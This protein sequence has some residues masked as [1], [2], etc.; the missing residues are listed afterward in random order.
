MSQNSKHSAALEDV[1]TERQRQ[2]ESD[3][4]T[5]EHDDSHVIGDLAVAAACYALIG[6]SKITGQHS[7]WAEIYFESGKD[8]W[9]WD[10]EWLKPKDV[11]RD[12][13]R[14]GALIIAEIE[15]LDRATGQEVA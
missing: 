8:L 6:A 3:G 14:A 2:I 9:P 7:T 13:V 15:R 10:N 1:A 4:F 11:R 12:L 5:P